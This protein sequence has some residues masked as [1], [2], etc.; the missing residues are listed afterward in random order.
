MMFKSGQDDLVPF[1]DERAAVAMHHQV[2]GFRRAARENDLARLFRVKEML[3]LDA[4]CLEFPGGQLAQVMHGAV[5]IGM[6]L[7]LVAH[8]AI[9]D[10]LWHLAAGGII[11]VDQR[12]AGN[13]QLEHGEICSDPLDAVAVADHSF[14]IHGF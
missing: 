2:D 10:R 1:P 3:Y 11:Q 5:D 12:F 14:G 8:D 9:D 4:R 7:T 13:L 6:L